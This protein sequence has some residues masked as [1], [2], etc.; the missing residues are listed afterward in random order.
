MTRL[1]TFVLAIL[2]TPAA[3][4]FI[5]ID[6]FSNPEQSDGLGNRTI[7]GLVMFLD[8]GLSLSAYAISGV[9]SMP[10]A[11]VIY[12]FTPTPLVAAPIVVVLAKNSQQSVAE[13][14]ILRMSVDN[15]S[16]S[17][18]LPGAQE[19]FVSYSFD[20]RSVLS[21]VSAMQEIRLDWLRED[22]HGGAKQLVID[23]LDVHAVAEPST[24]A[25]LSVISS[26]SFLYK[27]RRKIRCLSTSQS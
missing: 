19:N 3:A 16:L 6:E 25:L 22:G 13:T 4:G 1:F 12:H 5:T 15:H 23:S 21:D 2:T 14:G 10:V 11:S 18:I 17:Y 24:L 20:F 27:W 7:E 26:V 8:D 9:T